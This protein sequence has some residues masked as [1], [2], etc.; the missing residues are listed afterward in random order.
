MNDLRK[1]ASDVGKLEQLSDALDNFR[2]FKDEDV[3]TF[4]RK[5]ALTYLDRGWCT[6]YLVL[7]EIAFEQGEIKIEAYFT[8]SHKVLRTL[9]ASK[10]KIKSA[11]GFKEA[12]SIHFVLIGQLGKY[13]ERNDKNYV[14]CSKITSKEILDYAFEVMVAASQLIVCRCALVECSEEPKVQKVYSD[15]GFSY[16]QYDGDHYQYIKRI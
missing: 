7:N 15:Y 13:M 10:N 5:D 8:L 12:E 1:R 14:Q 3:E 6:I 11:S 4:L 2:C 16:F 9:N